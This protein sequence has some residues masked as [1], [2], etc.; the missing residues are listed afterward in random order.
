[1]NAF[2][3]RG[4]YLIFLFVYVNQLFAAEHVRCEFDRI[5]FILPGYGDYT[6][7]KAY[8]NIGL[9]SRE[10]CILPIFKID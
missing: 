1:M 7:E 3:Y 6:K 8:Q 5:I 2:F 9:Y 10:H 4:L